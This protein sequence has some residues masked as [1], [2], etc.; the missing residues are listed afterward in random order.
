MK[1]AGYF[2]GWIWG[3]MWIAVVAGLLLGF[4]VGY[5]TGW[6]AFFGVLGLIIASGL[7]ATIV[8][9]VSGQ[10]REATKQCPL[11]KETVLAE[12]LRC[13]HCGAELAQYEKLQQLE[14]RLRVSTDK[15]QSKVIEELTRLGEIAVP[16]LIQTL[17][18]NS[19][20]VGQIDA[21]FAL[22]E[23]RDPR[24]FWPLV[25]ALKSKDRTI[26]EMVA[27]ALGDFGDT[28]A[29]PHLIAAL[30]DDPSSTGVTSALMK[31]ND[32]SAIPGLVDFLAHC[33]SLVGESMASEA[34]E[35]FGSQA[36]PVLVEAYR[37]ARPAKKS[38][39]A[40]TLSQT[41]PAAV[42]ALIE[43]LQS[44]DVDTY[45]YVVYRLAE[46]GELARP[47][48]MSLAASSKGLTQQRAKEVLEF[49]DAIDAS[50]EKSAK[51]IS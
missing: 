32:P 38:I 8:A 43:L 9:A 45:K 51:E 19:N 7:I 24:A 40:Y 15:E 5:G 16:L 27:L 26:V 23:L 30:R 11:C 35:H 33:L 1:Q 12:A 47:T 22:A 29:V 14:S 10:F 48:L 25:N 49:M 21:A 17:Q 36:A 28:R 2:F 46:L 39:L 44:D 50:G 31:L 18:D 34:I 13:K 37:T 42:P 6:L 41:G 20:P 3:W 4:Y